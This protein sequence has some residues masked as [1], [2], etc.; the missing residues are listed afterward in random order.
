MRSVP[1]SSEEAV[2]KNAKGLKSQQRTG[3]GKERKEGLMK[4]DRRDFLK[5]AGIGSAVFVSGLSGLDR[6]TN[7]ALAAPDDFFFVQ[8]SDTHWGFT[9]PA[10]NP[11]STGTLRKAVE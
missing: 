6:L 1:E 7:R 10:V 11:D 2:S 4:I 9:G 3:H 8:F 5:L